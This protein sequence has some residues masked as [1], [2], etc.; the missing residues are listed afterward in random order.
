LNQAAKNA[1]VTLEN[2]CTLALMLLIY[3]MIEKLYVTAVKNV[4]MNVEWIF[5]RKSLQS[6]EKVY[7]K[8][9]VVGNNT[10]PDRGT[11]K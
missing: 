1:N 8:L 4:H 9:S 11:R 7:F 2:R 5:R 6:N 3:M 10:R